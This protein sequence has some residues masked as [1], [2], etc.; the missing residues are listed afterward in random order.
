MDADRI[1][2]LRLIPL[3]SSKDLLSVVMSYTVVRVYCH[4]LNFMFLTGFFVVINALLFV[5][6]SLSSSN[7]ATGQRKSNF[8]HSPKIQMIIL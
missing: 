3:V 8:N 1:N 7:L 5:F 2:G 4:V 6:K